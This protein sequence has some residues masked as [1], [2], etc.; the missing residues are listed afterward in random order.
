MSSDSS[1][2][3]ATPPAI[4]DS[5]INLKEVDATLRISDTDSFEDSLR[6]VRR[7]RIELAASCLLILITDI[8]I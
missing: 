1:T 7:I 2:C 4:Q 3:H 6:E 8:Q 5:F